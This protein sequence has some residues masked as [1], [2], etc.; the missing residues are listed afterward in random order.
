MRRHDGR[1]GFTLIECMAAL[2]VM[3]V[4]AAG[5]MG[6]FTTGVV[7]NGNARRITRATAIAEDLLA[8]I[9]LWPY[10]EGT[11]PLANTSTANDGDIG[12]T[13]LGFETDDDPVGH[14]LADH[15]EADLPA[16]WTGI[17]AAELSGEYERY[18]NVRYVDTNGDGVNDLAQVAAVVRWRQGGV[19]R[20][21]VLLSAKLNPAGS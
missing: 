2:S 6:L 5:L 3:L 15:G 21:V 13:A 1:R 4:G 7:L 11:G 17:P 9:A 10:Q 8:G 14:G 18:W 16:S 19:W 20:R 12:D